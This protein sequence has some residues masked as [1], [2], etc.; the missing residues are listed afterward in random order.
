LLRKAID[1]VIDS[2]RTNRFTLDETKINERIYLGAKVRVQLRNCLKLSR[3]KMPDLGL[4]EMEI[5]I[6]STI[7]ET[8]SI[9]PEVVGNLCLLVKSDEKHSVCSFGAIVI[10]DEVLNA[11]GKS[12]SRRMISNTG[13]NKIHWILKDEPLPNIAS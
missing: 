12:S 3:V 4:D 2:A 10:R 1:E 13:I 6:Q 7:R 9:P 5:G 8:W 11:A